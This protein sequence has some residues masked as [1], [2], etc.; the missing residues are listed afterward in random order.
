MTRSMTFSIWNRLISPLS[1]HGAGKKSSITQLSLLLPWL[2]PG[3]LSE[4]STGFTFAHA[5]C[6]VARNSTKK[7][8]WPGI[9][10]STQKKLAAI[11]GLQSNFIHTQTSFWAITQACTITKSALAILLTC[12]CQVLPGNK[13]DLC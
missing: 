6:L 11:A 4:P 13:L 3:D 5:N 7:R 2:S 9:A 8:I 12:R 10:R 1:M